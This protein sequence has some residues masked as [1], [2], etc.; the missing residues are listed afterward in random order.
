MCVIARTDNIW[1]TDRRRWTRALPPVFPEVWPSCE[2]R[3]FNFWISTV[4]YRLKQETIRGNTTSPTDKPRLVGRCLSQNFPGGTLEN[5][6]N[7]WQEARATAEIPTG[8]L[9][10]TIKHYDFSHHARFLLF[11]LNLFRIEWKLD[12]ILSLNDPDCQLVLGFTRPD[13]HRNENKC[14][15]CCYSPQPVAFTDG[16][17]AADRIILIGQPHDQYYIKRSRRV[18]EE[19]RHDGFHPYTKNKIQLKCH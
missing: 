2:P 13:C 16:G 10:N 15:W 7:S 6:K 4:I 1:K 18:V 8:H 9:T 5:N 17:V 14:D 3:I 12:K 11:P 19:F